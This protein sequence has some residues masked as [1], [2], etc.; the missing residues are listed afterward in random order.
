[1]RGGVTTVALVLAFPST[2]KGSH[3]VR[4]RTKLYEMRVD[5]VE[6]IVHPVRVMTVALSVT[7]PGAPTVYLA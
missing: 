7:I 1:M 4:S 3:D 6:M 5:W 2:A